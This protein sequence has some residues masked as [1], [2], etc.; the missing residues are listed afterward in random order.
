MLY[1]NYH[2]I[3]HSGKR[4]KKLAFLMMLKK[5]REAFLAKGHLKGVVYKSINKTHCSIRQP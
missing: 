2:R 1:R 3:M 5:K 4:H